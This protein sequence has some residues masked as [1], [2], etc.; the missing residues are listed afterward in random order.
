MD[1]GA[2]PPP[3]SPPDHPPVRVA[4]CDDNAGVRSLIRAIVEG[5]DRLAWAGEA[6]TGPDG[7]ELVARE[8]PDVL[9]LD[10]HMPGPDGIEVL[11]DVLRVSPGCRVVFYT[12]AP[13]EAVEAPAL[14]AGAERVLHKSASLD[15]LLEALAAPSARS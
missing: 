3:P 15:A 9:L 8:R 12:S 10:M 14:A 1:A 13:P 6:E 7:V 5:D 2:P 4:V 11:P